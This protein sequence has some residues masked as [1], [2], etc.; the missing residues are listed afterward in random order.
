M[1][2]VVFGPRKKVLHKGF[3]GSVIIVF[4]LKPHSALFNLRTQEAR[5]AVLSRFSGE[6]TEIS[7]AVNL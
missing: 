3:S 2:F 7:S 5:D 1:C 4:S 6:Q